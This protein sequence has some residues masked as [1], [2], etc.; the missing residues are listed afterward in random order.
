MSGHSPASDFI[1]PFRFCDDY[2]SSWLCLNLPHPYI[3]FLFP[4]VLV[5]VSMA[6]STLCEVQLSSAVNWRVG[7]LV[8]VMWSAVSRSQVSQC[9]FLFD[10][11]GHCRIV[12]WPWTGIQS[13]LCR[14]AARSESSSL[15]RQV[16]EC[17]VVCAVM[18][19]K[20]W[21][22]NLSR[23]VKTSLRFGTWTAQI[24]R[25]FIIAS[26]RNVVIFIF[27]SHYQRCFS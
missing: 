11:G 1:S 23:S 3:V 6:T 21:N 16:E 20:N 27:N 24:C 8:Q 17:A 26:L 12:G 10:A 5:R 15:W 4:K 14:R 25:N 22:C 13:V 2:P 7:W 9:V 19:R 18:V